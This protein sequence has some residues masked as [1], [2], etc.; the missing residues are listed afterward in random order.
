[1][2]QLS[3]VELTIEIIKEIKVSFNQCESFGESFKHLSFAEYL[4]EIRLQLK[5]LINTFKKTVNV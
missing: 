2:L 5:D 3:M 1:M 4:Q